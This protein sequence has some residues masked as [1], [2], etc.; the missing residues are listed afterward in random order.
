MN[1]HKLQIILSARDTTKKSFLSVTGHVQALAKNVFSLRGA[2]ATLAGTGGIGLLVKKSLDMA[3]TLGKT[4]DKLGLSTDAL[5]EYRYAASL[6]GI[7]QK[8]L[9]MALQRF[10]RRTAEAAQGKGEL[11]AVLE[12]YN[13]A[14]KDAA[15]NTRNHEDV[16]SDLADV[17]A[18][19]GSESER[20]RIAFKAFDSEGAALVNMLKNG[21]SAMNKI[22][23]DARSLGVVMDEALIRNSE[24]A[25]DELEK[26]TRVLKIQFMS[27]ALGIAPQIARIA[28]STTDWYKANQQLIKQNI[29]GYVNNVEDALSGIKGFYDQLPEG[30]VGAAGAGLVGR[31]LFGP[32]AGA[33]IAMITLTSS[34]INQFKR[35]HPE[36]FGGVGFRGAGI[37]GSW[38][39]PEAI[40]TPTPKLLPPAIDTGAAGAA[41][42]EYNALMK[43]VAKAQ[44]EFQSTLPKPISTFE[45]MESQLSFGLDETLADAEKTK[46]AFESM[47]S[48]LRYQ[49]TDYYDYRVAQLEQQAK[50][51]EEYTGSAV[52]SH[53]WLI[54]QVKAL[55]EERLQAAGQSNQYLIDLSE[56]TAEAIEDNFSKF[57]RDAFR[58]ELDSA[59][60]YFR[61]F[62]NSL[63][64]S[65]SDMLGQ[66]TKELLFGGGSSGGSGLFSSLLSGI[67]GWFGGGTS[68]DASAGLGADWAGTL[69]HKGG[70]VGHDAAPM[71]HVPAS[72]FAHAPRLHKGLMPDE[73]PAILQKGETV[74]PRGQSI[75]NVKNITISVPVTME[76]PHDKRLAA[77]MSEEMERTALRVMRE[78]M[79]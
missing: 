57:Y 52:L 35:D 38:G 13:I 5:Q 51:Y 36:I 66:M 22:R 3:D 53:Q 27:A 1:D 77:R 4:A 46:Q 68:M 56:R 31:A 79:R 67:G 45:A 29:A 16:L 43:E 26:L 69:W 58:G 71:R 15:G 47:Y 73:F 12:Q 59:A 78:E 34:K 44:A 25:N 64:D 11:K 10:T 19:T 14:V 28:E 61:A 37:T 21:S 42:K 65:F 63:T 9:D 54:E 6:A 32:Q 40:A 72:L 50:A 75:S 48:D 24:K 20:L 55:D 76:S 23:Q 49:S 8:T 33:I 7:E 60:D 74:I 70:K 41:T 39:E 18:T 30:V 2:F 17:I 62:C